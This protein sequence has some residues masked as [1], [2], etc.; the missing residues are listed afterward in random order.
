MT[1][2]VNQYLMQNGYQ[3]YGST[4][5]FYT[6]YNNNINNNNNNNSLYNNKII[7]NKNGANNLIKLDNETSTQ[8]IMNR[9]N[10]TKA[11][12]LNNPNFSVGELVP[13]KK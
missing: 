10:D 13:N 5:P 8:S 7:N 9:L 6:G 12:S 1:T 2:S 3:K 11:Y 4:T